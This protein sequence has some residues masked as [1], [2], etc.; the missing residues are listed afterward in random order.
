M[1]A[2]VLALLVTTAVVQS[3]AERRRDDALAE[4]AGLVEPLGPSLVE[5]WRAD[6]PGRRT[7][8]PAGDL[9][10]TTRDPRRGEVVLLVDGATG[11]RRWV[12][13]LPE[14]EDTGSVACRVTT[15]DD[16]ADGHV[17]CRAATSMASL[18]FGRRRLAPGARTVLV[19]LDA[20]TGDRVAAHELGQRYPALAALG[21]DVV[22]AELLEDGRARV[23]RLDPP[24]AR[25]RW[26]FDSPRPVGPLAARTPADVDVQ[27]GV[28]A[29]SGPAAWALTPDGEVLG[30]WMPGLPA[31]PADVDPSVD[32]S[33][34]PDRRIAVGGPDSTGR[35]PRPY[36]TV[37]RLDGPTDDAVAIP[38]PVLRPAV[39]DGSAT[40]VLLTTPPGQGL[41]VA[42]DER[43]GAPRWQAVSRGDAVV[44]GG[45]LH[46]RA[47]RAL[48]AVDVATGRTVWRTELPARRTTRDLL[49]DGR[50][51]LV[52]TSA[53][54]GA[55]RL[56][57]LGLDDGRER[58]SVAAPRGVEDFVLLGGRLVA[59]TEDH[60]I[61]LG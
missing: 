32:M 16:G 23:S 13:P 45:R 6:A 9:L 41:V 34:L 61:G 10:V 22:L 54:D 59:L 21:P 12:A 56:T 18:G 25:P 60:A 15:R 31:S 57:A 7:P 8:T 55:P 20:R 26:T 38:G 42:V 44:L 3:A 36:G 52:P 33:V 27:H 51:L 35:D 29:V 14:V 2:A 50:L 37:R 19:V 48:T 43:T 40:G 4:V 58:W 30:T 46:T 39:D 5:R 28:V 53:A 49:T 17:V 24:T 11:A 47:G 1:L